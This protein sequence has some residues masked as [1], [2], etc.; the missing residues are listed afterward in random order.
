MHA[1]LQNGEWDVEA[2]FDVGHD[3]WDNRLIVDS[4]NRVHMSAIDPEQFGG[5]WVEYYYQD[6]SG[7]WQ[8]ESVGSGPQTYQFA[9]SIAVDPNGV[10]HITYFEQ[11]KNDLVMA[12][13]DGGDWTKEIVDAEGDAGLFSSLIIGDDGR[14]HVSYLMKAA[15]FGAVKYATRG[16]DD[17]EWAVTEIDRLDDLAYGFV[18]AR[19]VTSLALDTQGCPW[20]AYSDEKHL[21]LAVWDGSEWGMTTVVNAGDKTMG[22]LVSLG[23]DPDDQP[24]I[25]Y[26]E[27]TAKSPI[28]GVIKYTKGTP[29]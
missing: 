22:Q 20:I 26:F 16:L 6:E 29:G 9:T 5:V 8:V 10:P 25:A 11:S 14:Y 15:T 21:K 27:I 3:G 13:R 19:N 23:L 2:V 28:N 18:G 1:V 24:H 7:E 17:S 12:T 4:Q